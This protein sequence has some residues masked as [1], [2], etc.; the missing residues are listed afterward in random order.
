MAGFIEGVLNQA[1][2]S[3]HVL[4]AG[5]Y[6]A[7]GEVP[8]NECWARIVVV[9]AAQEAQARAIITTYLEGGEQIDLPQWSC[10]R[11]GEISEGQF[12]Q[13]WQCGYERAGE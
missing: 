4:Q 12:T 1:G 9:H 11:C 8:P 10:P 13:C 5:L 6:G 7:A 2:I 3:A